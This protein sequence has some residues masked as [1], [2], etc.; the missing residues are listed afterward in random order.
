[1]YRTIQILAG[2]L[3]LAVFTAANADVPSQ[4]DLQQYS[5]VGSNME[6]AEFARAELT[7]APDLQPAM[8]RARDH[9]DI[10]P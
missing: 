5:V 7:S 3:L 10:Q 9:G 6:Q 8:E 2:S 1:M 4:R